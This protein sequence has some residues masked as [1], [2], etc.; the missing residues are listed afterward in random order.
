MAT[1][2]CSGHSP[3]VIFHCSFSLTAHVQSVRDHFVLY[4][5]SLITALIASPPACSPCFSICPPTVHFQ[6]RSQRN[7]VYTKV[8]S[9]CPAPNL[10]MVCS[11]RVR[12][13]TLQWLL[14]LMQLPYPQRQSPPY[15]H[16]LSLAPPLTLL[17]PP[18]PSCHRRVSAL[19]PPS[20]WK[21]L[22]QISRWFLLSSL[23]D[24]FKGRLLR[25]VFFNYP[26]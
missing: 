20:A 13:K 12:V 1:P 2:W 15:S 11:L 3:E 26:M 17:Q 10:L 4:I 18:W 7:P 24:W 9:R 16:F 19:P 22:P 23:G 21:V 25:E 5:L 6:H 14:G 8:R